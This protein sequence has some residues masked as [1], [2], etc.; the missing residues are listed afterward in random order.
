MMG[1]LE[2]WLFALWQGDLHL[3][4][5]RASPK[6]VQPGAHGGSGASAGCPTTT[7]RGSFA[8]FHASHYINAFH[9]ANHKA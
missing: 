8:M 1:N 5:P 7:Q 2:D 3:R 4:K 9:A 6:L